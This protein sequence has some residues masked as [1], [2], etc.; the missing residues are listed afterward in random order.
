M[1]LNHL[2]LPCFLVLLHCTCVRAQDYVSY[3]TG[4]TTDVVTQPTGGVCLMGG[5]TENDEA[6]RWFLRR[7]DGGDV[8]VLR[9]SGS[10]GYNDYF[11]TELGVSINSVRTIVFESG[12][13]AGAE[14]VVQAI[15]GAEAI[16]FAGGNQAN[17]VNYWRGTAVD[18]LIR[19]AVQDRNIVI[20]G[21]S[22]GMAIL[23]SHYYSATNGGVTSAEALA[24][25]FNEF[26]TID[27]ARFLDIPLLRNLITDTHFSERDRQGRFT[28]FMARA[29]AITPDRPFLG[30]ACDEYTAVCIDPEGTASVY[31]TAGENDVAYFV[32][33]SCDGGVDPELTA[34]VPMDWGSAED[35]ALIVMS[36]P[37]DDTNPPTFDIPSFLP[38][39]ENWQ[40]QLWW[41][42]E[43]EFRT[44]DIEPITCLINS[45]REVT[46]ASVEVFPNPAKDVLRVTAKWTF[47]HLSVLD[48]AGRIVRQQNLPEI[49]SATFSILGL[50]P[51]SYY[52]IVSGSENRAKRAFVVP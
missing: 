8:V 35:P 51:G 23:G 2:L 7:A 19:V 10:D 28:A 34:G 38:N 42:M 52:L 36:I 5:R 29:A 20:G 33:T 49:T 11:Y 48:S 37:G 15:S 13:A 32:R 30:V 1:T 16:W 39:E 9:A 31:G 21:T 27:T 24:D 4:D 44:T 25:P 41:A 22:A 50:S 14:E 26:M 45:T 17:Y 46:D 3:F 6:I 12:G 43:G 40:F 18:S 47:K